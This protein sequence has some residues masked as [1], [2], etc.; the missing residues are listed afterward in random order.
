M[1]DFKQNQQQ[2]TKQVQRQQQKLSHLQI[3]ALNFLEMGTQDLRDEIYRAAS[4][5]PAIEII[6]KK[7]R[8]ETQN[9]KSG[10][11]EDSEKY[12]RVLENT[13]DNSET[14]QSHL[15]HQLNAMKLSD[16]EYELSQKL[17]YNLDKNG[18][19]GSSISPVSLIN[20]KRPL[21]NLSMLDD[22]IKRI[23]KMDPIGV[24]VKN[25][26]ESLLI[27]ARNSE[28]P[29]RLAVFILDGHLELLDP[30]E[31][32]KVLRKLN[33]YKISW[34][35]KSFAGE[36]ILDKIKLNEESVENAIKFILQLN[37]LPA[38]GYNFD[39]NMQYEK[40]DVILSVEKK[41]GKLTVNDYSRGLICGDENT[42]FQIKYASGVLP[43]I[44]ISEDFSMDK[45]NVLKA[46]ELIN[47]LAFR[48][49]TIVLQGCAIV[50]AQKNFFLKG[51]GFL[52]ALT[53]REIAKKLGIH[54]STVSRMSG[55]NGSKFIQTEWGLFPASYFFSSGVSSSDG[56]EK[57][58]A[59]SIKMQI[60]IILKEYGDLNIS[61][62]KLTDLL[63]QKG[64]KIARRTVAKY[65]NQAGIKN[66]YKRK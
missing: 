33:E 21:Q 16:D 41:Q 43:E 1:A 45:E 23:Q 38:Q 36:I 31:P 12:N 62:S 29:D 37:P 59:E 5:N 35:K 27:Q 24:C 19:Y 54:E 46:Q 4:E 56:K 44:R 60:Q 49:S 52:N 34:H 26:E 18:F 17:I 11:F 55:K 57:I 25:A 53:R 42:Y 6:E 28:N 66:S 58:S 3:Q 50:D 65:R 22:C 9:K 8:N 15:M 64:I 63:N 39:S 48:E 14:L 51:P 47:N 13:E 10:N 20:K 40:P 7:S 61:D 30:P 32:V 2:R